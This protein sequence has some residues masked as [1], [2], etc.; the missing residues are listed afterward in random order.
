MVTAKLYELAGEWTALDEL[1][2]ETEGDVTPEIEEL[3]EQ[4]EG[5]TTDKVQKVALVI[6]RKRAEAKAIKDEENRVVARRKRREHEADSLLGYLERVM[7]SIGKE[8]IDGTLCTVAFQ[9]NPPS[10]KGEL[11]EPALRELAELEEGC[12]SEIRLVRRIPESFVLD[13]KAALELFKSGDALPTGLAV[14]QGRS[15]RIR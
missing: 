13:K 6:L 8:R 2:A 1:L 4:L 3:L 11:A 7:Q 12:A 15:L 9:N 10:V 14:E 5:A